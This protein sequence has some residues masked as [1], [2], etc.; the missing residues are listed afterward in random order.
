MHLGPPDW[1]ATREYWVLMKLMC[2]QWRVRCGEGGVVVARESGARLLLAAAISLGYLGAS[3]VS[4]RQSAWL[5]P[6][7]VPVCMPSGMRVRPRPR[8]S[9]CALPCQRG[10]GSVR[11]RAFYYYYY[12][13][14]NADCNTTLLPKSTVLNTATVHAYKGFSAGAGR[15]PKNHGHGFLRCRSSAECGSAHARQLGKPNR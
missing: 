3:E 11:A 15:C 5:S 9:G 14:K 10:P 7:T 13:A 8:P 1:V 6:R 4:V 12:Y 2:V